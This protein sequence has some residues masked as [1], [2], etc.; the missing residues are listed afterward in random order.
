MKIG[1]V[2]L[3]KMGEGMTR[4]LKDQGHEVIATDVSDAARASAQEYGIT[5]TFNLR[6]L[7]DALETPRVIWTMVPSG[8]ITQSVLTEL[9]E[10]MDAGDTIINGANEYYKKTLEHGAMLSDKGINLIDV[11]VSG[12][13]EGARGGACLMIGGNL[14]IA[15]TYD[16]LFSDLAAPSAYGY[17]GSVGAGHYVKMVHNGIEYGMMQAIAE[18]FDILKDAP[19][20][21]DLNEVSRVYSSHSIITSRLMSWT[22]EGLTQYGAD[23][24][25]IS[26]SAG[27]GGA[28]G[29]SQSEAYW[30][31]LAAQEQG[32]STPVL[33][34]SLDVR[35]K[36]QEDPSFQGK[37]INM[38]RNMFGGHKIK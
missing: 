32:K 10:M 38:M 36:S 27:S 6:E 20:T 15:Q 12:G 24:D 30:T 25:E 18:G 16:Q 21:V 28:Q 3:G 35:K 4:H 23:L 7:V 14:A 11:G 37:M 13:Q 29:L 17:F 19:F 22:Q 9:S 2:G 34:S 8:D 31:H 26:G 5:T 1:Y 33:E